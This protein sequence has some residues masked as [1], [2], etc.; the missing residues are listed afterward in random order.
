VD[1]YKHEENLKKV[2]WG[3][4]KKSIEATKS[5]DIFVKIDYMRFANKEEAM[6]AQKQSSNN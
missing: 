2:D 1:S 6:A 5:K 3:K 4:P